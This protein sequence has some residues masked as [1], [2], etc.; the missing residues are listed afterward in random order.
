MCVDSWLVETTIC[1]ACCALLSL[2][3]N[4]WVGLQAVHRRF[5]GAEE[6]DGSVAGVGAAADL[7]VRGLV[8]ES[9]RDD[10]GGA[11]PAVGG[12]PNSGGAWVHRSRRVGG[13]VGCRH[14][15]ACG[16]IGVVGDGDDEERVALVVGDFTAVCAGRGTGH[17]D[18]V[19]VFIGLFFLRLF[20]FLVVVLLVG[21]VL[22][23]AAGSGV[24]GGGRRLLGGGGLCRGFGGGGLDRGEGRRGAVV[25]GIGAGSNS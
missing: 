18:L 22:L 13:Q 2:R 9:G 4:L 14:L 11:G 5:V 16:A 1:S 19:A 25:L 24:L 7:A 10:A 6:D 17:V 23:R 15:D 12:F 20:V 21:V 8:V 3:S